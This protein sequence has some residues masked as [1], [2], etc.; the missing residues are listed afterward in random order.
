MYLVRTFIAKYHLRTLL[1][2]TIIVG[3]DCNYTE[4][5]TNSVFR[6]LEICSQTT[7]NNCGNNRPKDL[8]RQKIL[9]ADFRNA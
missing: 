8:V 9:M 3:Y 2:T 6:I 4:I 1:I 5:T 7:T